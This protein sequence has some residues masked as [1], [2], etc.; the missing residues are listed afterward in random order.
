[1]DYGGGRKRSWNWRDQEKHVHA[2]PFQ[3]IV[4]GMNRFI[5][6]RFMAQ[7]SIALT[8]TGKKRSCRFNVGSKLKVHVLTILNYVDL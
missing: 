7:E 8:L 6:V 2:P 5:G 1:M 4:F 3:P